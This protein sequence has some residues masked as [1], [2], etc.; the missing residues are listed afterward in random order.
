M[1]VL[2]IASAEGRTLL[3]FDKDFGDLAFRQGLPA[4]GG[5]VL[6][7]AG[8]PSPAE[9]ASLALATLQSDVDWASSF[10][11]VNER[12]MRVRLLPRT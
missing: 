4:K 9:S 10:C 5:V 2:A 11:V 12:R 1:E 3:T 7:R 8:L 6:F